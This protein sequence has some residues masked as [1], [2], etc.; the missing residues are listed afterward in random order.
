MS[1]AFPASRRLTPS[2]S[3]PARLAVK[4]AATGGGG[5]LRRSYLRRAINRWKRGSSRKLS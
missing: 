5:P 1:D 3:D 2:D 4:A